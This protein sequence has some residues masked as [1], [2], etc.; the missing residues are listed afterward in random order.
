MFKKILTFLAI[1]ALVLTLIACDKDPEQPK[2]LPSVDGSA[3]P[4]K[5]E[6]KPE[7]SESEKPQV[8]DPEPGVPAPEGWPKDIPTPVS[9]EILGGGWIQRIFYTTDIVYKPV[10]YTHLDVYKRQR[11][12]YLVDQHSRSGHTESL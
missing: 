2:P 7:P 3:E 11:A 6:P 12:L 1:L 9:G 5:T 10:S 8:P 4:G